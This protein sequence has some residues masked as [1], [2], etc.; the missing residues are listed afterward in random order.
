MARA[1]SQTDTSSETQLAVA[2]FHLSQLP[3]PYQEADRLAN[4]PNIDNLSLAELYLALGHPARATHYAL[5]AYEWAWADGE[6]YVYRYY[7]NKSRALL[8]KLNVPIPD[9]PPYDP[10]KREPFPWEPAV[11][12]AIAKL[13][14]EKAKK[15]VKSR[16]KPAGT[17]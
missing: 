14:A 10:S 6:P 11:H 2:R 8:E 17:E 9:L 13:C 4:L 1:I 16:A 12:A 7:L 5:E 15:E 3:D